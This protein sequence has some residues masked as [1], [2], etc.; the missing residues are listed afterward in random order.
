MYSQYYVQ[1]N[2]VFHSKMLI[3]LPVLVIV[4]ELDE[5]VHRL[6]LCYLRISLLFNENKLI[7]KI[8]LSTIYVTYFHLIVFFDCFSMRPIPSNTFVISYIRRFCFVARE[9]A[10][11]YDQI[12]NSLRKYKNQIFRHQTKSFTEIVDGCTASSH[13]IVSIFYLNSM[14]E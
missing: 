7:N 8:F 1:L 14:Y 2:E 12:K 6:R 3:H 11:C 4:L 13:P 5:D 10:T 9:S